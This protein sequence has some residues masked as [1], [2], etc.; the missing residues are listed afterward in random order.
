MTLIVTDSQHKLEKL[1]K[2]VLTCELCAGTL[3]LGPRPVVRARK[4]HSA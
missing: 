1:L 3:P 4:I 2:R